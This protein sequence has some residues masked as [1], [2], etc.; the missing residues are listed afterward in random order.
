M[1]IF[2]QARQDVNPGDVLSQTLSAAIPGLQTGMTNMQSQQQDL[3]KTLMPLLLKQKM[4]EQLISTLFGGGAGGQGGG[5]GQFGEQGIGQGG[6]QAGMGGSPEEEQQPYSDQEVAKGYLYD[7]DYGKGMSEANSNFFKRQKFAFDKQK[8]SGLIAPENAESILGAIE[9]MEELLPYTGSALVPGKGF[10]GKKS[11]EGL[12]AINRVSAEKRA[13]FD[14]GT[15]EFI[16]LIK[17]M[18]AKGQFSKAIFEDVKKERVPNS[19]LTNRENQGRLNAFRKLVKRH[20]GKDINKMVQI[21]TPDGQTGSI[22]QS[23]LKDFKKKYPE[24]KFYGK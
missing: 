18:E 6:G 24:T 15:S 11:G 3:E 5:A 7:S 2:T 23:Q 19:N 12:P 20:L 22:P 9:E 8:E 14:T 10:A 4:K 21:V 1:S 13:E 16:N 17:S